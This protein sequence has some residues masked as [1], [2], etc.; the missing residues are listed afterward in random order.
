MTKNDLSKEYFEWMLQLVYSETY[1]KKLSYRKLLK[2]LHDIEFV[3]IIGMDGNRAEDGV[4]LRYR[5]GY[6]RNYDSAMIASYLDDGPCS[7][8]EMMIALAM[9][10]E[11][12]IMDNPEI[13][14]RT[15]QWFWDMIVNLKLGPMTNDRFNAQYVEEVISK[16]LNREYERNGQGGLFT[17]K[18][19]KH[20]LRTVEIWYQMCWYLDEIL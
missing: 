11:E 9:R 3:Y 17:V 2:Q 5:F 12:N 19:C 8:L 16:L 15:G 1:S 7:V 13:G 10:C 14:N 6:E 20:D 18:N 4:N